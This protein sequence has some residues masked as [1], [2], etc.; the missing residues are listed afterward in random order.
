MAKRVEP[1]IFG[2]DI[3]KGSLDVH[4]YDT[5]E[6]VRIANEVSAIDEFL[7]ELPE[8]AVIGFESTGSYHEGLVAQA[9]ECGIPLYEID[10]Y[11]L[12]HYRESTGSRA[13]TD[14]K[15]A[16]LVARYVQRELPSLRPFV[17]RSPEERKLWQLLLRRGV[18]VQAKSQL[19]QSV[20]HLGVAVSELDEAIDK[21]REALKALEKHAVRIARDL[22]WGNEIA[23]VQAIPGVGPLVALALVLTY[24][25]APFPNRDAYIAYMGLDVRVRDSGLYRGQRKLTKRGEPELRR[26]MFL[27]GRA[28]R[29]FGDRFAQYYERLRARGKSTTEADVAVARKIARIAFTLLRT[30]E[31]YRPQSA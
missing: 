4:R 31:D 11:K 24:H 6:T 25:R 23:R 15:D 27:A 26:V 30:G 17:P 7:K 28:G 2:I 8:D 9:L 12:R 16:E 29:R 19:V 5:G 10:G 14:K 1:I 13:K 21:L 20:E 3:A 22:G 18:L